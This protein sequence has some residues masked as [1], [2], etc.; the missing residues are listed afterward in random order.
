[1]KTK[2]QNKLLE[3]SLFEIEEPFIIKDYSELIFSLNSI[4]KEKKLKYL[5]THRKNIEKILYVE[6]QN[7]KIDNDTIDKNDNISNYFF[8]YEIIN[9][10]KDIINYKYDFELVKELYN[11][12]TNEKKDLRKF[13]LN[14][15]LY[16]ILYNFE[17]SNDSDS[18][19]EEDKN[20]YEQ[21]YNYIDEFMKKQQHLL[22]EYNL[23]LDLLNYKS[24]KIDKI[25]A[26]IIISLIRNKKLENYECVKDLEQLDIKNIDLTHEMFIELKKEFDE[27]SNKKYIADYKFKNNEDLF[28]ER[29]INF[30]HILFIYIFKIQFYIFNIKFLYEERN[31]LIKIIKDNNEKIFQKIDNIQNSSL[32]EKLEDVLKFL[33]SYEI[34]EKNIE[35]KKEHTNINPSTECSQSAQTSN[36]QSSQSTTT[37]S[38]LE[39]LSGFY[40]KSK[41][42]PKRGNNKRQNRNGTNK[43][44]SSEE[45]EQKKARQEEVFD[46]VLNNI[47]NIILIPENDEEDTKIVIEF[48]NINCNLSEYEFNKCKKFFSKESEGFKV[49]QYLEHFLEELKNEYKN[50]LTLL[51]KLKIN[52]KEHNE[53]ETIYSFDNLKT[54]KDFNFESQSFPYFIDEINQYKKDPKKK[55]KISPEEK[56]KVEKQSKSKNT[57]KTRMEGNNKKIKNHEYKILYFKKVIGNHND[58]GEHNSATFIKEFSHLNYRFIS[59]GTDKS[60]KLYNRDFYEHKIPFKSPEMLGSIIQ[61]KNIKKENDVDL[62]FYACTKKEIFLYNLHDGNFQSK[63]IPSTIDNVTCNTLIQIEREDKDILV[64]AGKGGAL[65]I[66]NARNIF[67]NNS[68][69]DKTKIL[70]DNEYMGL[71]QINENLIALTSNKIL[72]RGEDKLV[73]FNLE[74]PEILKEIKDK[75]FIASSNGL[76]ILIPEYISKEEEKEEEEEEEEEEDE[77][78]LICACKKYSKNQENGILFVNLNDNYNNKFYNTGDFEVYCFCQIMEK[79]SSNVKVINNFEDTTLPTDFFLVGGFD[80]IKGEGL[81][82][83]YKLIGDTNKKEIEFLQDI[84]FQKYFKPEKEE[85][86][87]EEIEK[88][89]IE[90]VNSINQDDTT[91]TIFTDNKNNNIENEIF[92]GFNG[93]ISSII[94]STSSGNILVSCYD[95][96]VNLF[97]EINIELYGKKLNF[98]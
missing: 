71:I 39:N 61:A 9:S 49:F 77:K 6:D 36:E 41:K 42:R 94:Q 37:N 82:K 7:L 48:K 2:L 16:T 17:Q 63:F 19:S 93:A 70:K 91:Y 40:E 52:K 65:Y 50:N 54:Y 23:K 98:G 73:I 5:Y 81:I 26:E 75:S 10:D 1:M 60:L 33:D 67:Y 55:E 24:L 45:K 90:K 72:P 35:E 22:Q 21:I 88:E 57:E 62:F 86:E 64:I 97:S 56:N 78:Y 92:Y 79:S 11:K 4:D 66:N 46:I 85:I 84:E 51:I 14:I 89:E 96:K 80:K 18:S 47:M 44:N 32:K 29:F 30:Y 95:G 3:F 74:N 27:N 8:L 13:I 43:N 83:L 53:Y 58:N 76:A 69:I 31:S 68:S 34:F 25:Y 28:K 20:K 59:G 38:N 87:K 15:L 12:I